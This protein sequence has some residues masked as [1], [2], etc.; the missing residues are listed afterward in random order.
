MFP[1]Y[2]PEIPDR[3]GV[4]WTRTESRAA[5]SLDPSA[6]IEVRRVLQNQTRLASNSVLLDNHLH[7]PDGVRAEARMSLG[8]DG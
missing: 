4:E 2:R 8:D 3:R 5:E 1:I 6:G 7:V